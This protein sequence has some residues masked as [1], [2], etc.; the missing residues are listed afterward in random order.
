MLLQHYT[1]GV[2]VLGLFLSVSRLDFGK[3]V[4]LFFDKAVADNAKELYRHGGFF[5]QE[6][7]PYNNK[8][9][10]R[11]QDKFTILLL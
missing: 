3:E 2:V 6:P 8:T 9:C 10:A 5:V 4:Q 7:L 1:L 11:K